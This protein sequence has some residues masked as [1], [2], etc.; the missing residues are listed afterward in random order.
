MQIEGEVN[1]KAPV[2]SVWNVLLDPEAIAACVPGCQELKQLEGDTY[3]AVLKVGVGAVS[4]TYEGELRIAEKEPPS[5]YVMVFE[6]AGAQGFA[7]GRGEVKL[8]A[9]DGST[10]VSYRCE[11]E[12]GGLIAS[13]GQ[14]A[15]EGVGK[16]V[17]KKMFAN[18]EDHVAKGGNQ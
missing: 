5:R 18:L 7:K 2:E 3:T 14:R 4:G 15:L 17:I 12:V 10:F 8:R 6:G 13:V 9:N 11:V 1:F 16:F